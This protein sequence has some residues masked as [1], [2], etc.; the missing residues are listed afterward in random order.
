MDGPARVPSMDGP[1]GYPPLL[2]MD[3]SGYPPL[4]GPAR[5]PPPPPKSTS[6]DYQQAGSGPSTE[7]LTCVKFFLANL[8]F[9]KQIG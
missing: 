2:W 1:A 3:Q 9:L 4:D 5:V 6:W 8:V 7:R